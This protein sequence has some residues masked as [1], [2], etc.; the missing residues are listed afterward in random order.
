MGQYVP[1]TEE[2]VSWLQGIIDRL[3][4]G[5]IEA[6]RV[7]E[8]LGHERRIVGDGYLHR[9][10]GLDS[11]E[12]SWHDGPQATPRKWVGPKEVAVKWEQ[13]EALRRGDKE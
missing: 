11:L 8:T 3:Q 10:N 6:D 5:E 1:P 7:T 2:V 13:V 12:M 4:R 9:H